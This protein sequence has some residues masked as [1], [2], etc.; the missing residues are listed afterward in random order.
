MSKDYFLSLTGAR[1]IYPILISAH[2]ELV[3]GRMGTPTEYNEVGDKTIVQ[4][5]L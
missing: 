3:E 1:L 4:V 2:P 5:G